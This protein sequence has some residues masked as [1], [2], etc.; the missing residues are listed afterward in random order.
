M[1]NFFI[2]DWTGKLD[3]LAVLVTV[4]VVAL[5][6]C[7]GLDVTELVDED[8]ECIRVTG[9]GLT[10]MG[11]FT[12]VVQMVGKVPVMSQIEEMECKKCHFLLTAS[13]NEMQK[14]INDIGVNRDGAIP[15]AIRIIFGFLDES[16]VEALKK[17]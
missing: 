3:R 16:Y 12:M 11:R 1:F 7:L 14:L 15:Q 4:L 6:L 8:N 5:L 13:L 17:E 9:H 10:G 2:D